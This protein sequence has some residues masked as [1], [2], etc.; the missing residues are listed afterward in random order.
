MTDS[1]DD[2]LSR[3]LEDLAKRTKSIRAEAGLDKN[4]ESGR[5]PGMAKKSSL[6]GRIATELIVGTAVG[7]GLGYAFDEWLETAPWGMVVG[8]G[9]GFAGSVMT[10]Y[11]MVRGY[12][13]TVGLGRAARDASRSD[14]KTGNDPENGKNPS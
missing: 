12:D 2:H 4:A 6:G 3:K 10:I 8:L 7:G 5:K 13:E 9:F 1:E 14:K 11:R